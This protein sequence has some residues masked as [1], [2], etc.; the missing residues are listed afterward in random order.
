MQ[1]YTP[2]A[3]VLPIHSSKREELGI[4]SQPTG[5]RTPSGHIYRRCGARVGE[6]E[7][8]NDGN[9]LPAISAN[10]RGYHSTRRRQ[11]DPLAPLSSPIF[12]SGADLITEASVLVRHRPCDN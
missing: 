9:Y 6:S 1:L 8:H 11:V 7:H 5:V 2:R 10:K 4:S 3:S 12:I